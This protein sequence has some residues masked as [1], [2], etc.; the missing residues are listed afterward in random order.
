MA[1]IDV[2][3]RP[4][5]F[6]MLGSAGAIQSFWAELESLGVRHPNLRWL[7]LGTIASYED[8]LNSGKLLRPL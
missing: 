5:D 7:W 4:P 2:W 6:P 3:R 1:C 8:G